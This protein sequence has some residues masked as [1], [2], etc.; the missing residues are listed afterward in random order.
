MVEVVSE[1]KKVGRLKVF[2]NVSKRALAANEASV[3]ICVIWALYIGSRW[4]LHHN[5]A[6][7]G[8]DFFDEPNADQNSIAIFKLIFV[9]ECFVVRI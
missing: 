3:K 7:Y 9:P 5:L 8:Q 6:E 1:C 4:A 2:G